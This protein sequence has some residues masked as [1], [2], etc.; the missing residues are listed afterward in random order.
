MHF[1]GF[2]NNVVLAAGGFSGK[3]SSRPKFWARIPQLMTRMHGLFFVR[4]PC[5][6]LLWNDIGGRMAKSAP[7]NKTGGFE[8][9]KERR[10]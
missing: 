2:C 5:P 4:T 6:H 3:H 10:E 7:K 8:Q 9:H 1:Q